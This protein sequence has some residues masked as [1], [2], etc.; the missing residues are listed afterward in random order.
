MKNLC[1]SAF[2]GVA[3]LV[4]ASCG[5]RG[6]ATATYD[7]VPLPRQIVIDSGQPPF[8]L[9][10]ATFITYPEFRP[11][12]LNEATHLQSYI[13]SLTG[14]KPKIRCGEPAQNAINL[15]AGL[16]NDNPEAYRLTVSGHSIDINGAS[17]AGLFY[18]IQTLRKSI[19]PAPGCN[20]VFPAASITDSP[21]FAYR[22]TH[23]DVCRHFFPVDSIKTFIDVLALHNVNRF[24]WHLNDDQG[25][26]VEIKSR[27]LLTSLAS[28]RP[29]TIVGHTTDQYDSIPVEGFYTQQQIRDIVDYAAKRHITVV[30]E[31]DMPGH[32]IAALTAYPHLGC[33]GGPYEIWQKWGVSDHV[34]CA[35]NDS[36]YRFIEDVLGEIA[37]LFPGELVH[38]GGD[39]CPKTQ[40]EKCPKCQAKVTELG[41]Q[42]TPVSTPEQQL[43]GHITR[44][45][46]NLLAEKGKRIIGWEEILES[47]M[48]PGAVVMS[49][50]GE[51][52]GIEAARLGHD[53]IMTPNTYLYFDYYQTLDKDNEPEAISNYIPLERVYSYEPVPSSLTPQEAAHIIG[54][55]ANV[56]TEFIPTFHKVLYMTLPRL[57]ALSEVQWSDAPKDYG[58]FL[59]RLQGLMRHYAHYDYNHS[60]RAFD[61]T[62]SVDVDPERRA[63][64]FD[65]ATTP[66][67][68]A[69]FY[70][71]DGTDPD[72]KSPLFVEPVSITAASQFRAVAK[73]RYGTSYVYKDSV[74]FHKATAKRVTLLT[75]PDPTYAAKG[76]ATL[77]DGRNGA[78]LYSSGRWVGF[79][80]TDLDA[81][82]DLGAVDTVSS[83]G[84]H[85]NVS[86]G[87]W[88]FDA[89]EMKVE[90]STDSIHWQTVGSEQYPALTQPVTAVTSKTMSFAPTPARYVRL[91]M[92]TEKSMP[93]WH[94][95]PGQPAFLFVDEITVE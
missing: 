76:G 81:V 85:T 10:P 7:V 92:T 46:A 91:R 44:Y 73:H 48:A 68:D 31:I 94:T 32:M 55:Q 52:P 56:W 12:L 88:I 6:E 33:T 78:D 62:A 64:V 14:L 45:A 53:A 65:L 51:V 89:K 23:L 86:T 4:L 66:G 9:T 77:V 26:R 20:I 84:T 36:T 72:E 11:E 93:A 5:H 79:H 38:I 28:S 58:R 21:R 18:G 57:A 80:G 59:D 39:E 54:V 15:A 19:P 35:G 50:R 42:A 63:V 29:G 74:K 67:S 49:W 69:I 41:I 71:L 75:A 8:V 90:L 13:E 3:C 40:W 30:P 1:L 22:G 82:I 25:W 43:Q 17:A 16:D 27:P 61:V 70:T 24:H 37:E 83:V 95:D 2:I 60:L 34:L 47:P 87:V